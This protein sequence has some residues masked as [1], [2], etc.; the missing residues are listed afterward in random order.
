[1]ASDAQAPGQRPGH[2]EAYGTPS[3][4][5]PDPVARYVDSLV[6]Q[7]KALNARVGELEDRLEGRAES[8]STPSRPQPGPRTNA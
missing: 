3:D 6:E 1:M 2:F 5:I 8:L 7:V 4:E